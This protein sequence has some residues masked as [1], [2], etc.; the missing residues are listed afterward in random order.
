[1][2]LNLHV[3]LISYH[4]NVYTLAIATLC[5]LL[6]LYYAIC[7]RDGYN[8][9]WIFFVVSVYVCVWGGEGGK[10]ACHQKSVECLCANV[11]WFT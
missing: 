5:R 2:L 9:I 10:L 11:T 1:M 8:V 4:T 7:R 6:D 3:R